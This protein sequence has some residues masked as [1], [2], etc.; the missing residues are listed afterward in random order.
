MPSNWLNIDISF[1]NFTGQES[2]EQQVRQMLDYLRKLVEQLRYN[3]RHLDIPGLD[4]EKIVSG[5]LKAR[6]GGTGAATAMANRILAGPASGEAAEPSFRELDPSDIPNLDADKV[7]SGTFATARIPN[8]AASKI[9]SGILAVAR[10]GT[11]LATAAANKIFAGPTSGN[12]AAPSWRSLAAADIPNLAASKITSGILAI[13][14]GGTG[15]ATAAANK[16]FA[17][18]ASGDDAAPSWRSLVSDDIPNLAAGKIT[19]G[20]F[21]AAR[22]PSLAMSKITDLVDTLAGKVAKAGDTMTGT[23]YFDLDGTWSRQDLSVSATPGEDIP[24]SNRSYNGRTVYDK[25][26]KNIWYEYITK[27]TGDVLYK[28]FILARQINNNETATNGFYLRI[29]KTGALE[30]S[31]S[32]GGKDAWI[33]GLD[34]NRVTI[35]PTIVTTMPNGVASIAGIYVDRVKEIVTVFVETLKVSASPV[36]SWA[37]I[38]SGL[39]KPRRGFY[40]AFAHTSQ[41]EAH[42][43]LRVRVTDGGVL[44]V[45]FGEANQNYIGSFTYIAST[46]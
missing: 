34:L 13:A 16:I 18:P 40:T 38:A 17:G 22:I 19:S 8:L 25:N 27:T 33:K 2:S 9:T 32:T 43:D 21:A 11:G 28:S 24:T 29:T 45:A 39:P 20:T 1:P 7:T 23:L 35:T 41:A 6:H 15:A 37:Q 26:N 10:G 5:I 46:Y 44:Q 3:F 31:F 42:A 36:S 12:D 4:A 30:V 14:R